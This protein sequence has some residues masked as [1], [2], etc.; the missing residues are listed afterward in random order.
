MLAMLLGAPG[1]AGP[2]G[3]A[4]PE[5]ATD[6]FH[7]PKQ[8]FR[9]VE[10]SSYGSCWVYKIVDEE[11][12]P[13][14]LPKAFADALDCPCVISVRGSVLTINVGW[15]IR[16]LDLRSKQERTLFSVYKDNEGI[17]GPVFSPDGRRVAFVVIDQHKRHGQKA[18]GRIIVVDTQSDPPA[19]RKFDRGLHYVCGSTCFS[20][21]GRDFGFK[22]SDTLF[23]RT[24]EMGPEP[25]QEIE[26]AL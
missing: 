19:L 1:M 10:A 25:G 7:V 8:P 5:S 18:S 12:Q 24:H 17:S 14:L 15:T 23:Y 2:G 4:K 9:R 22:G 20:T 13:V 6:P 21:E 26:I 3:E 16:Q 11:G